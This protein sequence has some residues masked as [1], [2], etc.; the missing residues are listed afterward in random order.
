MLICIFPFDWFIN[1]KII[2][3]SK[4][5]S[6]IIDFLFNIYICTINLYLVQVEGQKSE[7]YKI[8]KMYNTTTAKVYKTIKFI[9]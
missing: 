3:Y 8:M 6:P 5:E 7:I 4:C 2:N 1:K 9:Q